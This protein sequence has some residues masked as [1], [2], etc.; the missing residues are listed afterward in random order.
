MILNKNNDDKVL[1]KIEEENMCTILKP[2]K[3]YD[4]R[5]SC[6]TSDN[7]ITNHSDAKYKYAI[8]NLKVVVFALY[9]LVNIYLHNVQ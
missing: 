9:H 5:I 3:L 6:N 1:P 2:H 4:T 7:F 8:I